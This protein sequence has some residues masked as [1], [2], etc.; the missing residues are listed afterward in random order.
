MDSRWRDSKN[1]RIKTRFL[2]PKT[3]LAFP[4]EQRGP[5]GAERRAQLFKKQQQ[6]KACVDFS[7]A[8]C[9]YFNNALTHPDGSC[10]AG[11]PL[12]SL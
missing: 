4:P 11:F 9:W 2:R 6:K 12:S 3:S 5:K 8:N 1:K 10:A 7:T